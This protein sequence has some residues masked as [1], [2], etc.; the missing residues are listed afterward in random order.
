MMVDD[1]QY[2]A[3]HRE[4]K[5]SVL[6]RVEYLTVDTILV[7]FCQEATG[8]TDPSLPP[9]LRLQSGIFIEWVL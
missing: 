1:R 2:K 5:Y 6:Y 7:G 4:T 8:G 3:S 9:K